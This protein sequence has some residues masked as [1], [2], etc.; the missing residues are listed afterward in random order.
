MVCPSPPVYSGMASILI[1]NK[2]AMVTTRLSQTLL[3]YVAPCMDR[4]AN[5]GLSSTGK[6]ARHESLLSL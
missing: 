6:Y 1:L 3:N 2:L 4:R 5:K